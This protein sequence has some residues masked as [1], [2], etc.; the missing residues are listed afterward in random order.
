[1]IVLLGQKEELPFT[2]FFAQFSVRLPLRVAYLTPEITVEGSALYDY[3]IVGPIL[4]LGQ[5]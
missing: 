5:L 4:C 2:A 1:M 3:P